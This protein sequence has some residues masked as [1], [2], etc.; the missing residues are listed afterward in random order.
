MKVI[1]QNIILNAI[2]AVSCDGVLTISCGNEGGSVIIKIRD[3]GGGIKIKPKE[4][5]FEPFLSTKDNGTGI[6]LW[7]TKRLVDS[8]NGTIRIT[9]DE[10]IEPG[11]AEFVIIIPEK[12][13]GQK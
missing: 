3:N 6:G 5:I 9:E 10:L 12:E 13:E 2:Q 7:I 4:R 1:L 8:M 11:E